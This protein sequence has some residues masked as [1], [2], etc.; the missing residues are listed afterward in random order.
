[1]GWIVSQRNRVLATVTRGD[2]A[3]SFTLI[4]EPASAPW[5]DWLRSTTAPTSRTPK[6][7]PAR[8]RSRIAEAPPRRAGRRGQT[9]TEKELTVAKLDL[10]Q[11]QVEP[12]FLYN[13]LAQRAA[14]SRA[15][16]RRSARRDA[17]PPD[18]VPAP[19]AAAHRRTR[20]PRLGDELERSRAYL[21]ILKIRMGDAPQLQIDVPERAAGA[22]RF[23]PMMLQTLVENAI[24][25][26]LEPRPGG[27][28]VW[29]FARARRRRS[30]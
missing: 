19:L 29:I 20:C 3:S 17:G 28:T 16:M 21:E 4:C 22:R 12:H 14:T 6:R 11:A 23:P 2:G 7:W 24:K 9:A 15:A 13:T 30:R 1:M 5:S 26:G 27:G 10:L 8:S 18:P 25:H